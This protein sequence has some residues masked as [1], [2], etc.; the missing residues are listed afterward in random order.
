MLAKNIN[1]FS[2]PIKIKEDCAICRK[3][4][5]TNSIFIICDTNLHKKDV[6]CHSCFPVQKKPT[7]T[8]EFDCIYRFIITNWNDKPQNILLLPVTKRNAIT[9]KREQ[10][11]RFL[12][13]YDFGLNPK[14]MRCRRGDSFSISFWLGIDLEEIDLSENFYWAGIRKKNSYYILLKYGQFFIRRFD[15]ENKVLQKQYF[16]YTQTKK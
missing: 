13:F 6:Y 4:T 16:Q 7:H 8:L 11:D 3:K 15:F 9:S 1:V 14:D 5:M 10:R 12:D 2:F